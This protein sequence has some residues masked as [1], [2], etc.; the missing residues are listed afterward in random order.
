MDFGDIPVYRS[1]SIFLNLV[2]FFFY[3]RTGE[4]NRSRQRSGADPRK[5]AKRGGGDF[6]KTEDHREDRAILWILSEA[7][8]LSRQ[9]RGRDRR[10]VK[11]S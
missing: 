1:S 3:E 9:M 8:P 6:D 11:Y 4:A 5:R 2:F 7:V 10:V